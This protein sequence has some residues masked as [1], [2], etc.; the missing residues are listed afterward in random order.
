MATTPNPSGA[1]GMVQLGCPICNTAFPVLGIPGKVYDCPS[2]G[3]SLKIPE[4]NPQSGLKTTRDSQRR[5]ISLLIPAAILMI[6]IIV[7]F[8]GA[9]LWFT[10]RNQSP[11]Q[12]VIALL[13]PDADAIYQTN[14]A[15]LRSNPAY[16]KKIAALDKVLR[17]EFQDLQ[18]QP[19]SSSV[20]SLF[21]STIKSGEQLLVFAFAEPIQFG[22]TLTG[23]RYR[24]MTQDQFTYQQDRLQEA[25]CWAVDNH[26][27]LLGG[28]LK[29][30][31]A[32][33]AREQAEQRASVDANFERFMR[34]VPGSALAWGTVNIDQL[35]KNP[36][37]DG[38]QWNLV[39]ERQGLQLNATAF[40][41]PQ[42]E[43]EA[44]LK[45]LEDLEGVLAVLGNGSPALLDWK[46]IGDLLR[47]GK[48][49]SRGAEVT[50]RLA[51]DQNLLQTRLQANADAFAKQRNDSWQRIRNAYQLA[52]DQGDL[53]LTKDEFDQATRSFK[54]ALE[55]YPDG[56]E[57]RQKYQSAAA[58]EQRL[59]GFFNALAEF[60]AAHKNK[61]LARMK[62]H[63]E[64]ASV[65]LRKDQRVLDRAEILRLEERRAQFDWHRKKADDA[66]ASLNLEKA[67][68]S[69]EAAL[70][71]QPMDPEADKLKNSLQLAGTAKKDLARSQEALL[72]NDVEEALKN[73]DG[74]QAALRTLT[75]P[76]PR[77]DRL[78]RLVESM[79][80]KTRDCYRDIIRFART[81]SSDHQDKG[82]R[83]WQNM[84]YASSKL[85]YAQAIADLKKGKDCLEKM[86]VLSPNE[87]KYLEETASRVDS[88]I[89]RLEDLNQRSL[90]MSHLQK[91]RRLV[92]EG[93]KRLSQSELNADLVSAVAKDLQEAQGEFSKAKDYKEIDVDADARE[94]ERQLARAHTMVRPFDLNMD[95]KKLPP[96]SWAYDKKKWAA[97]E[98]DGKA[99][100]QTT[101]SSATLTAPK[102]YF[103]TD[104][105]LQVT[106]G[107][108][109]KKGDLRNNWEY[110]PELFKV[111]LVGKSKDDADFTITLGQDPR[112]KLQGSAAL[113][114]GTV[115]HGASFIIGQKKPVT[116]RMVRVAGGANIYLNEKQLAAIP[117]NQE[118]REMSIHI[119][120][121]VDASPVL[122][123]ASLTMHGG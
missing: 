13:P 117:L 36:H 22:N 40:F 28:P 86:K 95:D 94:A 57:A 77:D 115:S 123:G 81:S 92:A 60:D 35:S 82:D 31:A 108:L 102:D 9:S 1:A 112:N 41:R 52:M 114:A 45:E 101:V 25:N 93:K 24:Q 110:Y 71:I 97:V 122:F 59:S 68:E 89:A 61:N 64:E 27:R 2:C 100:L 63:L 58:K 16:Q 49:D 21:V 106:T 75:E 62:A 66:L 7:G 26:G 98:K 80:A 90:G 88:E 18:V 118:F 17:E 120:K 104:F 67:L 5:N 37:L 42:T 8:V 10:S 11:L 15:S 6:M 113:T 105:E 39:L 65:Y 12:S 78:K 53:A 44:F 69:L 72:A 87:D 32:A 56:E 79:V 91:G 23:G 84:D 55:F 47:K 19:R 116:I 50:F 76:L 51:L 85:E 99:R 14:F 96:E 74:A 38:L 73:V 4:T 119:N 54:K 103:P 20:D 46:D 109:D 29:L 83:N 43:G 121:K 3:K 70:I 33:L 34:D 107:L 30:I 111:V 48:A